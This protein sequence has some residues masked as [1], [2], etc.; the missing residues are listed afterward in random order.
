MND[1]SSKTS[2]LSLTTCHVSR[3]GAEAQTDETKS[4]W[5]PQEDG[6]MRI[7][8]QAIQHNS[9]WFMREGSR[10]GLGICPPVI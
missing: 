3:S 4:S 1:A 5:T 8:E 9:V 10:G 6:E 2:E 7:Y